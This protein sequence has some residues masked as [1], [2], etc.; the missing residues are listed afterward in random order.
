MADLLDLAVEH[1]QQ[2]STVLNIN[3]DEANDGE[4]AAMISFA[5]AF[6]NGF[7][8]LCDTYETKRSLLLA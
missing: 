4:L 7:M 1:R 6:P 2:L 8:V 3:A 5:I